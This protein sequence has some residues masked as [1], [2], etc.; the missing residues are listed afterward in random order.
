M[1]KL[2]KTVE[3]SYSNIQTLALK[4]LQSGSNAL[5]Y[6]LNDLMG[7][8]KWYERFGIL[9]L[10]D[11]L[12]AQCLKILGSLMLKTQELLGVIEGASQSFIAFFKWLY[13]VI[14]QLI[15]EEV[16][17]FVK[18]FNQEDVS[19][20]A[21]FLHCQLGQQEKGK[22]RFSVERVGQYLKKEPLIF[23]V[24]DSENVW[25]KFSESFPELCN[26]SYIFT[27]DPE[28][29]LVTLNDEL[30]SSIRT[31]FQMLIRTTE[32]ALS[33]DLRIPLSPCTAADCKVLQ[34]SNEGGSHHLIALQDGK[35]LS[36][37]LH[38]VRLSMEEAACGIPIAEVVTVAFQELGV[39]AER[40][41]RISVVD[42]GFYDETMLTILLRREEMEDNNSDLLSQYK[43][44]TLKDSQFKRLTTSQDVH[45]NYNTMAAS[46]VDG[47]DAVLQRRSL[48]RMKAIKVAVSGSRKVACVLS[49]SRTRVKLFDMDAD[50]EDPDDTIDELQTSAMSTDCGV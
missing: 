11:V 9:G 27:V 37:K 6:H 33:C 15:E 39:N 2:G 19:L 25:R 23:K 34:F 20:V 12:V 45:A 22:T 17:T 49:T 18:K 21:E 5:F 50:D 41:S 36:E 24:H 8:A 30:T 13:L 44:S 16:P 35:L 1:K 26:T 10:S 42:F 47:S 4:N 32:Q 28:K 43:F 48:A 7:M 3:N 40:Q 46:L 31:T 14:L 29:S 38:L